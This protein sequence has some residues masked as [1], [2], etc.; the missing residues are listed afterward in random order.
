[1]NLCVLGDARSVHLQRNL[2]GLAAL[3]ADVTLLT[4]NPA[5]IPGVE[6]VRFQVPP[7]SWRY[8]LSWRQRWRKL[9]REMLRR[10]DVVNVQFLHDWG[11]RPDDTRRGVLVLTPWGS[12]IVAPPG[13]DPP[14]PQLVER[15]RALLCAAAVVTTWGPTFASQVADFAGADV[16]PIRIVPLGVDTDLFS[17]R[18]PLPAPREA[19][20]P[21]DG[22][23]R[24]GFFKG[25]RAVYGPTTL[26]R[27]IPTVV[28]EL[29]RTRFHLI[30]D[31]PLVTKCKEL[32]GMFG[33]EHAVR[34]IR[35][36]P[37]RNLPNYLGM[38]DLSVITSVCESFGVSALESSAMAVP[39]VA[40]DV[41]GLRDVV[42]NGVTGELVPPEAPE[43]LADAIIRLLKDEPR[44]RRLGLS[45][46][47][48]VRRDYRQ[49]DVLRTWLDV[50]EE[51]RQQCCVMV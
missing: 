31:G 48:R 3:G 16:A 24:V 5:P 19:Q 35:P 20:M 29:P 46:M 22:V 15:R 17:P 12:D 8:P 27:A 2:S 50:F 30:G 21:D 25:F 9:I 37:H 4:H 11:L 45:G 13:E 49:E 6:V 7:L 44:R 32:S 33:V 43:A 39:V 36:Q 42:I 34:W 18:N 47:E 26:M 38:W 28:E 14:T 41:G 51:A 40:T 1:M 10:F 23:Q